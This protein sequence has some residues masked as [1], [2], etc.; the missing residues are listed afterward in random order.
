MASSVSPGSAPE[1]RGPSRDD[2]GESLEVSPRLEHLGALLV[3]LPDFGILICKLC[4]FAIQP[5]ALTSHL[6]R[7]HIPR[8]TSQIA[9]PCG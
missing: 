2:L 6:L 3:H 8:K 4:K 9:G 1:S 5:K 7:H